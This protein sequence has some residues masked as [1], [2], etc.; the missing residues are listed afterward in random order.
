MESMG[1]DDLSLMKM[2][3][4]RMMSIAGFGSLKSTVK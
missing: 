4:M 3:M 2:M 1:D